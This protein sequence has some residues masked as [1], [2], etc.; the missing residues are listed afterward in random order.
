MAY[1]LFSLWHFIRFY[2]FF[3]FLLR[4]YLLCLSVREKISMSFSS[5]FASS[6][7]KYGFII[8]L[9]FRYNISFLK[10]T[11]RISLASQESSLSKQSASNV[12]SSETR[13]GRTGKIL[14]AMFNLYSE[15]KLA[16]R[17]IEFRTEEE[18]GKQIRFKVYSFAQ[19]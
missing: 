5:S 10:K 14:S 6:L 19:S 7:S 15:V 1:K 17:L 4:F 18:S 8:I 9:N 12:N 2:Y 3:K 13:R 16:Q 11:Q